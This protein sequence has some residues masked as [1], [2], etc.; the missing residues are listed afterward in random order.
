MTLQK[1]A[2]LTLRT[3][4]QHAGASAVKVATNTWRVFGDLEA[5]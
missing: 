3:T 4:E 1:A 5:A 2:S